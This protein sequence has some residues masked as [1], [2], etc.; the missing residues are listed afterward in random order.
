M[1]RNRPPRAEPGAPELDAIFTKLGEL[2]AG[3]SCP[4]SGRCCRF[5]QTG[6]TPYVFPV[7]VRRVLRGVAHRG[8]R[9]PRGGGDGDCP[10]LLA[11]GTCAVY[12]DRPFGCR[13][14]FCG[15]ATLPRGPRRREVDALAKELRTVAERLGEPELVPLTTP[16]GAA[17]DRDGRRRG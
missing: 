14:Y 7:E 9:L 1:T 17:F 3:A 10:L 13:T 4:G 8:G 12:E 5:R 6:R 16:L 11:E 15:D 2:F